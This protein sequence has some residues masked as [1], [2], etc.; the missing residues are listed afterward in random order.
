[1]EKNHYGCHDQNNDINNNNLNDRNFIYDQ[2]GHNRI[3]FL[4]PHMEPDYTSLGN[5]YFRQTNHNDQNENNNQKCQN[6]TNNPLFNEQGLGAN[7]I[8]N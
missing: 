4:P 1:M 5:T 8:T 6:F 7:F 3:I 2:L